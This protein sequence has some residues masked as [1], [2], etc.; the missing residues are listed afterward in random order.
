MLSDASNSD[1]RIEGVG[2]VVM[3][4]GQRIEV[5]AAVKVAMVFMASNGSYGMPVAAVPGTGNNFLFSHNLTTI[6]HAQSNHRTI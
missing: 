4:S 3:G 5:L 6:F 2:M 1:S